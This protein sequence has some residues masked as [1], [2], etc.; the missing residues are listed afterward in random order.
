MIKILAICFLL[1]STSIWASSRDQLLVNITN[2]L[3]TDCR[4]KDQEILF[5][6]VSDHTSIPTVIHPNETENFMMRSGPRYGSGI[7]M[8]KA[9]LLTYA[10]DNEQEI[11]LYANANNKNLDAKK[12]DVKNMSATFERYIPMFEHSEIH[13]TLSY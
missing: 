2:T 10:C 3:A 13:W 11:T 4:L 5:G 6:H 9:F 12:F 1:L 8:D 7:Y